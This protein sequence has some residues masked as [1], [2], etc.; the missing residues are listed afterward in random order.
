MTVDSA[1]A[2]SLAHAS[3]PILEIDL[4]A[5]VKNYRALDKISGSAKV[6]ASVKADAYGLGAEAVGKALFAA[7]CRT[8]FVAHAAEGKDLRAY[9]RPDV[10]IYTLSGATPV[11]VQTIL[12]AGLKPVLNSLA[13]AQLWASTIAG[14]DKPPAAALHFDTGINRLGIP[15]NE[16]EA[17][18]GDP[19]FLDR[20]NI[21]LIMSH[22]ACS[23]LT[24]H[25]M[26][27]EQKQAFTEISKRFPKNRLSLANTGGI[28]LG[29]DYHFDLVRPGIGLYGGAATDKPATESITPVVSLYAPILQIKNVRK[30]E[31]IGYNASFVAQKNMVL[32]TASIGYA[33]G[34][35]VALSGSNTS[36]GALARIGKV[37]VPIVG[38]VSMDYSILDISN[39]K[40][41]VH[42]GE[43]VEF[44]GADLDAQAAQAGTINYE[45][46]TH[47]G[48]RC[49]RVY[50]D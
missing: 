42:L 19:A 14:V 13:Q 47:L 31:T 11:G 9:L 43:M 49:K 26:N 18:A 3:R 30:G 37:S 20:L 28:Y 16:I 27:A 4:G 1:L 40:D 50:I 45:L 33:D 15:K 24:D 21:D 35:P 2:A 32:A 5:V 23:S 29:P 44:L 22:L 8:F 6:G 7:G 34:L 17:F 25:P 39:M 10:D 36:P 46:L 41:E 12:E 48:A 38:R